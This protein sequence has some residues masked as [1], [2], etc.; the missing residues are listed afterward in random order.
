MLS[1]VIMITLSCYHGNALMFPWLHVII[2]SSWKLWLNCAFWFCRTSPCLILCL[3]SLSAALRSDFSRTHLSQV[4]RVY[5]WYEA[6]PGE[7]SPGWSVPRTKC[8]LDETSHEQS[9]PQ[10]DVYCIILTL[11]FKIV[12]APPGWE[13]PGLEPPCPGP[14][15]GVALEFLSICWLV[16]K[17]S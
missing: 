13:M 9:V 6:T 5:C 1:H 7:T 3:R 2:F 16:G 12:Y 15:G 8:P 11:I 4:G 17:S 10:D 14:P